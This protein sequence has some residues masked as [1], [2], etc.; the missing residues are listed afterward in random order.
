VIKST[1]RASENKAK[2][3]RV[4]WLAALAERAGTR[5]FLRDDLTAI[6]NGW[7]IT[8]RHGGL[9]R[10]YRDPRFDTLSAC[11]RCGGRGTVAEVPCAPC[12]GTGRIT[13]EPSAAGGDYP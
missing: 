7:Q 1:S 9:G 3:R 8:Q 13:R 2:I 11:P 6:E 12:R 10:R 4:S 5:L